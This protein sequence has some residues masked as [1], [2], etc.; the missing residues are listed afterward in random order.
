M[1]KSVLTEIVRALDKKEIRELNKWLQSPAHNQRQDV[2]RLFEFLLKN[3]PNGDEGAEK[4][5]AWKAVFPTQPYDDAYM[6]QVMYFLLKSIEEYLVFMDVAND[7]VQ[8]QLALSR[9]YRK[10]KLDKSYKQA[11]RLG[12]ESLEGQALR[13]DYYLLST[14]F[15]AQEEYEYKMSIT[16]NAPVNLQETA[17]AL[18]KWFIEE[19]LRISKDM[20][21]HHRIYQKINY[22]HGLLEQTL[23]YVEEKKML[24]EPAIAVYYYAYKAFINPSEESYFER[25]EF[26]IHNEMEHF[27]H[28]EVRTLYLAALNYCVPKINQGRQDFYRKAFE[29]YKKGVESGI[30]MENGALSRYTFLNT[31]SSALKTLEFDWA[32]QFINQ[33]QQFLEEKHRHGSVNFSLSRLYFEKGDYDKAQQSLT[34]FEYDDM[35]QNIVAKTMLLK[36]YYER[37]DFDAFESLLESMRTYLQRKEALDP[38]RKTAYKNM[39]SAMKKL[40]H[41]NIF[42]KS[43]RE[44]FREMVQKTTPLMEREWLLEQLEKK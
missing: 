31:V 40:L 33:F 4:A 42:S 20:I 14:F 7:R 28:S 16:Q 43:Q 13:N 21:A 3:L 9:I 2:V 10:R 24:A 19:R 27:Q 1:Q 23:S 25:L 30:L 11:H 35:L 17:D 37:D 12:V 15:L 39:I 5:K 41:L 6:R 22:D 26:L 38:S 32:E 36:I 18:E 34:Q 8:Y 29:L 44:T